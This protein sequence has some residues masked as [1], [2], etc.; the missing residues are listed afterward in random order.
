MFCIYYLR[1]STFS[2]YQHSPVT[3]M[4]TVILW[5][6]ISFWRNI[7]WDLHSGSNLTPQN[8]L[9]ELPVW[10]WEWGNRYSSEVIKFLVS[11]WGESRRT[12][13]VLLSSKSIHTQNKNQRDAQAPFHAPVKVWLFTQIQAAPRGY[14]KSTSPWNM[15]QHR[16]SPDITT[17]KGKCTWKST[18]E[19]AWWC[20]SPS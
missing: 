4:S 9:L 7:N 16:S 5:I 18:Q 12:R 17:G 20:I 13:T 2:L 3:K 1:F 8:I 10:K 11:D 19:T 6:G 15:P 14:G